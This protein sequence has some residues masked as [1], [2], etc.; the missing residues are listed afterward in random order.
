[1]DQLLQLGS[2]LI[3]SET[4]GLVYHLILTFSITGALLTCLNF[5]NRQVVEWRRLVLGL[6]IL[7]LIQISLFAFS[8]LAWQRMVDP[9]KWL[10]LLERMISLLG[11]VLIVWL[12]AFPRPV[13]SADVAS[14]LLVGLI[15]TG[16]V[17]IGVW[18]TGQDLSTFLN[19]TWAGRASCILGMLLTGVGIFLLVNRKPKVWE[20]GSGM[21]VIL[22]FGY[23]FQFF[24]GENTSYS[25][26]IRLSE[27]AAYPL[28]LV[29]PD[30]FLIPVPSLRPGTQES[31]SNAAYSLLTRILN[32]ADI[33]TVFQRSAQELAAQMQSD[34]CFLFTLS[35]DLK[36]LE[37]R[38]YED[39]RAVKKSSGEKI[40][41]EPGQVYTLEGSRF[42]ILINSLQLIRPLR[43]NS[44]SN[45]PDMVNLI[46]FLQLDPAGH[47]LLV[48]ASSE[49]L[50]A[51]GV[52]FIS[53]RSR[54]PWSQ[55]DLATVKG[56]IQPLAYFLQQTVL[57]ERTKLK[58]D[59][60][61]KDDQMANLQDQKDRA[62]Y[63]QVQDDFLRV[64]KANTD[65]QAQIQTLAAL[66]ALQQESLA[67]SNQKI[68]SLQSEL[69]NHKEGL[70]RREV[71]VALLQVQELRQP[72]FSIQEYANFL[73]AESMGTL[74]TIQRK[75]VDGIRQSSERLIQISKNIEESLHAQ[76]SSPPPELAE[77]DLSEI[78][79]AALSRNA[80]LLRSKR[81][82]LRINLP[83]SLPNLVTDNETLSQALDILI[84][85]AANVSPVQGQVALNAFVE[86][87]QGRPDYVIIQICDSGGGVP[88]SNLQ[89]ISENRKDDQEAVLNS[90]GS[91]D[92][93]LAMVRNL[94]ENL[95]GRIWVDNELG[96]GSTYSV[97]L[98]MSSP[99]SGRDNQVSQG[100]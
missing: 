24:W 47:L 49:G 28:L 75:F 91:L 95:N 74:G 46:Q 51:L 96:R 43:L 22:L 65:K 63:R 57:M 85:R 80:K 37:I 98:P 93:E 34:I 6:Y 12:W 3:N 33:S 82:L 20:I 97:L 10:P 52:A 54:K 88:N 78:I 23:M 1:M 44:S 35:E 81:I 53:P 89:G 71:E 61:E 40:K 58:L 76:S 38:G 42:P 15:V 55:Q 4:G 90:A 31:D 36:F 92:N 83:E 21:L 30:R 32:S 79:D 72:L 60:L 2:Q 9:L 73:L 39:Q 99:T 7:L 84:Q 86:E 45:T 19:N 77:F 14:L 69:T 48:P 41:F 11:V 94:V 29:L 17:L 16:S 50:P 64:Q 59:R 56:L 8:A 70:S 27:L 26:S 18:W 62:M 100:S 87:D 67:T 5:W 13:Q 25:A 68:Q 66:V